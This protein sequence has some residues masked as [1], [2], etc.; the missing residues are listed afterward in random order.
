[1]L[2]IITAELLHLAVYI[3]CAFTTYYLALT[4]VR[5]NERKSKMTDLQPPEPTNQGPAYTV[6]KILGYLILAGLGALLL[7]AL[8][9]LIIL[10]WRVVL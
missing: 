3:A 2:D 4:L 1:M 7:S 6:G 10:L 9:V 5:R 8:A